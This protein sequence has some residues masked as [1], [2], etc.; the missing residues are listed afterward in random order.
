MAA[1]STIRASPFTVS[2]SH[3][4]HLLLYL[5]PKFYVCVT[6]LRRLDGDCSNVR[7]KFCQGNRVCVVCH[8][9]S[10]LDGFINRDDEVRPVRGLEAHGH[11]RC[12][13]GVDVRRADA[14]VVGV[15]RLDGH[16]RGCVV[17]RIDVAAAVVDGLVGPAE[18]VAFV[19][20]SA[21]HRHALDVDVAPSARERHRA[22]GYETRVRGEGPDLAAAADVVAVLVADHVA[23]RVHGG[24]HE[25]GVARV[26]DGRRGDGHGPRHRCDAHDSRRAVVGRRGHVGGPVAPY[27]ERDGHD[28]EGQRA[29]RD[30]LLE[31]EWRHRPSLLRLD[32]PPRGLPAAVDVAPPERVALAY[33]ATG[34]TPSPVQSPD[35]DG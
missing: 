22:R 4:W 19:A 17:G 35:V 1:P 10:L 25:V 12:R 18:V 11:E 26:D 13:L 3:L 28:R 31:S 32:D 7:T 15:Q 2:I 24:R 27:R 8:G 30:E 5:N 29:E 34:K 23:R 6:W 21:E 9:Y 20:V 16:A 33:H 14:V